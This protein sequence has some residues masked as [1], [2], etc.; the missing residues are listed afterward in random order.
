M[1]SK[2]QASREH[3][4]VVSRSKEVDSTSLDCRDDTAFEESW[5]V[6]WSAGYSFD[7]YRIIRTLGRGASAIVYLAEDR[8]LNRQIA[9]KVSRNSVEKSNSSTKRFS[10]EA[11]SVA[12]L[13][14]PNICQVYDIGNH[15][16]RLFIAMAYVEG[17]SLSE[18]LETE[19]PSEFEVARIIRTLAVA[20]EEAHEQGVIHRDLKPAN[21]LMNK[22]GEPVLTDFGLALTKSRHLSARIT[23]PGL[24][25]GSP[26]YMSPEQ[27]RDASDVSSSSDVYSLGV[28]MYQMLC[29]TLPFT[30]EIMTVIR[31]I[32]LDQ[33]EPP[34]SHQT[35]LSEAMNEIC[36]KAIEK[37]PARR[38]SSMAEF[39]E[40]LTKVIES[41]PTAGGNVIRSGVASSNRTPKQR[42]A[43]WAGLAGLLVLLSS[44]FVASRFLVD[45]E[46]VDLSDK[47]HVPE[48]RAGTD[49]LSRLNTLLRNGVQIIVDSEEL[50]AP[51]TEI[52]AAV[53]CVTTIDYDGFDFE[54]LRTVL[55]VVPPFK[56]LNV[57]TDNFSPET[58]DLLLQSYPTEL[59]IEADELTPREWETIGQ[60]H[61]LTW[62]E[63][64]CPTMVDSELKA[65][66]PL[67]N[68]Q[69][70]GLPGNQIHGS[71][72]RYFSRMKHL[73]SLNLADSQIH[74]RFLSDLE[75]FPQLEILS[76]S[77]TPIT[78]EGLASLARIPQLRNL[79]VSFTSLSNADLPAL[80]EFPKLTELFLESCPNISDLSP[81]AGK[82][83]VSLDIT[84]T[85]VTDLRPLVT[86]P[87]HNIFLNLSVVQDRTLLRSIP[88]LGYV[89]GVPFDVDQVAQG[90]VQDSE[91][92]RLE[93]LN[94][95][96][97]S[98]VR[99]HTSSQN[100]LELPLRE[101]PES[102]WGVAC[103][104]VEF[105]GDAFREL[106]EVGPA[107]YKRL[108]IRTD[109][110][111][112]ATFALLLRDYPEDLFI[113]SQ[114]ITAAHWRVIGRM[115][116]L[117]SLEVK[118]DTI[119]DEDL[120]AIEPLENLTFLMLPGNKGLSGSCF[121]YLSRMRHLRE[122]DLISS[123][124][125]DE[126]LRDLPALPSL[127]ALGLSRTQ[128][129]GSGLSD[130]HRLPAL[131]ILH[132]GGTAVSNE[133]LSSIKQLERLVVL[134]LDD[135][136]Q[137]TDLT[138]LI[139]SSIATLHL[140]GT[141]VTDLRPI[142]KMKVSQ[143]GVDDELLKSTD[144]SELGPTLRIVNGRDVTA[145]DP[146]P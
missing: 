34:S 75:Y 8:R 87:I 115:R 78:G 143:L 131:E 45:A 118:C 33:P 92:S 129:D 72:F 85:S 111:P 59:Y 103:D 140:H 11:E 31:K 52:P 51:L 116:D 113:H 114:K 137:I 25:V 95:L 22:R 39:A 21:V 102:I 18:W 40:A 50:E 107:Q 117:K 105:D 36:L 15:Q 90:V 83:I 23:Q 49:R 19:S 121:R 56:R 14:H 134:Y 82:P 62:L 69:A 99:L 46:P 32:A 28:V 4:E 42:L 73:Y 76:L 68:L 96:C 58:W 124:I 144:F 43:L 16:G 71:C 77:G 70:L 35:G 44:A 38:F 54:Q 145:S 55:E 17:Q 41:S 81:L 97:E 110:V 142:G 27:I 123:G 133:H 6:E 66:Q 146:S 79:D 61:E 127:R 108:I 64:S 94:A 89:N 139:G 101:I 10:R 13:Q 9:L 74:D 93:R 63:L 88:T 130:L 132:L 112:P 126:F 12:R 120:Q 3:N 37:D 67:T 26:A 29:G 135:C 91:M 119:V 106:L 84:N 47:R 30:G 100:T 20:L 53:W 5:H 125:R 57:R 104:H 2:E 128:I 86:M 7:R 138:P 80:S 136:A 141:S 48:A 1:K 122:I 65:L 60:M 98:G 24:I 109:K